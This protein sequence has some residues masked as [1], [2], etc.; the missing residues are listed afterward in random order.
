[1]LKLAKDCKKGDIMVALA[2]QNSFLTFSIKRA[3]ASKNSALQTFFFFILLQTE[4][5]TT[6]IQ[7]N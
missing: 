7:F 1:M 3:F 6:Y 5:N 2:G 4:D